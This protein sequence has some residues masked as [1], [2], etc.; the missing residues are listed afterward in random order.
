MYTCQ[1][2]LYISVY[3]QEILYISVYIQEILYISVYMSG[4]PVQQC[5]HSTDPG[6]GD[7]PGEQLLL[8]CLRH[9]RGHPLPLF[10]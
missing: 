9:G 3:I 8:Q 10:L 6:V 7:V 5:M 2:I 1:E 4:D